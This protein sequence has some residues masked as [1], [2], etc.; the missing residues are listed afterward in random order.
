[1]IA[2]VPRPHG[3]AHAIGDGQL[4]LD[5]GQVC[6]DGAGSNEQLVR[7]LHVGFSRRDPARDVHVAG[8]LVPASDGIG[9]RGLVIVHA[10]CDLVLLHTTTAG[11]A[12]LTKYSISPA[13]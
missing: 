12:L 2:V 9:G 6:F 11:S 4:A 1:M 5:V 10:L 7:D 8:R 13:W 3:N